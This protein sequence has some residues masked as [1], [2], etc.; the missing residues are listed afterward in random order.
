MERNPLGTK[1]IYHILGLVI[2]AALKWLNKIRKDEWNRLQA[3][4]FLLPTTHSKSRAK[5]GV[6][7]N[8]Q[9]RSFFTTKLYVN[10]C[11]LNL[12]EKLA[13]RINKDDKN[14]QL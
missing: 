13:Y 12:L 2:F 11:P 8:Y 4:A 9:Q 10:N 3:E 5:N 14:Y 7:F 6:F 1:G